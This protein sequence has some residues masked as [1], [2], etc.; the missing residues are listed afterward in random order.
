MFIS[1][2]LGQPFDYSNAGDID[3]TDMGT[4]LY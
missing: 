2:E 1:L 3:L 4:Y